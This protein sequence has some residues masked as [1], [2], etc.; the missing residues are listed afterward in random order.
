MNIL[1]NC[2]EDRNRHS[3][4]LRDYDYTTAGA[5]FVTICTLQRKCLF[6]E[7]V[8]DAMQLN[9]FGKIVRDEW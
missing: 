4:R 3:L 9:D 1:L 6:G 5:Y 2:D 8:D 7:L